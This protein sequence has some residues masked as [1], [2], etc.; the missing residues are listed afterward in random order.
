MEAAGEGINGGTTLN[1]KNALAWVS[2][3][4]LHIGRVRCGGVGIGVGSKG[5]AW[6]WGVSVVTT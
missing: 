2:A 6:V 4:L 1:G 5:L 3:I